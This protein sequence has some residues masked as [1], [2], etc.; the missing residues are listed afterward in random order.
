M[1]TIKIL[2]ISIVML[3]LAGCQR[4][5]PI[6]NIENTPITYSLQK[7]QVK[8]AILQAAINRGWT[9]EDKSASEL[10]A[11]IHVRSHHAEV[12]IPYNEKHYSIIYVDSSNLKAK[13]GNIH[14]NY[15][16]WVNNLNLDIQ[17]QFSLESSQ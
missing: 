14:R 1:S 15:N 10:T 2:V 13:S 16:R 8:S 5:Q 7:E 4:V 12:K 17:K 9:I 6:M 3:V 11:R